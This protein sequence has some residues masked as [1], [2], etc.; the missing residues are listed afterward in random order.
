MKQW[1]KS[2]TTTTATNNTTSNNNSE[3]NQNMVFPLPSMGRFSLVHVLCFCAYT[4]FVLN[5][6]IY[7]SHKKVHS[8]ILRGVLHEATNSHRSLLI[9]K[10]E[11]F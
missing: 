2:T 5:I 6:V 11:L 10:R 8:S 9:E 4:V 1:T 7:L 3:L